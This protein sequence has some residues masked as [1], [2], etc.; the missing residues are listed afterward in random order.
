MT[1]Y[2]NKSSLSVNCANIEII[3]IVSA[4]SK[5][6]WLFIEKNQTHITLI[7][8]VITERMNEKNGGNLFDKLRLHLI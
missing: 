3:V 6:F 4:P 2:F 5:Y 7:N 1:K 8:N